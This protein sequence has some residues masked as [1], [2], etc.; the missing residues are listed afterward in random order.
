LDD[1]LVFSIGPL[2]TL[3]VGSRDSREQPRDVPEAYTNISMGED[4]RNVLEACTTISI[5]ENGRDVQ[6]R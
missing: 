6:R 3:V 5:C 2:G 4:G 1:L